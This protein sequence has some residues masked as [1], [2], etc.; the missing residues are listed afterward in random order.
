MVFTDEPGTDRDSYT[1]PEVEG[2]EYLVDGEV[3]AADTYPG[4]GTVTVTARALDGFVLAEGATTEWSH[5]FST[6]G[7]D[8]DPEPEPGPDRRTAEFHLSNTWRA[9]TDVHFAYGRW[10][11]EVLIGDWN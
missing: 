11:D 7:G 10:A 4:A 5:E 6:D 9:S 8:P 1:V 2:V 3:V